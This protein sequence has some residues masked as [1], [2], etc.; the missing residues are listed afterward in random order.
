M[1][2]TPIVCD[3][4]SFQ[5]LRRVLQ[6]DLDIVAH[7]LVSFIPGLLIAVRKDYPLT[8]FRLAQVALISVRRPY[9]LLLHHDFCLLDPRVA[10]VAQEHN[11]RVLLSHFIDYLI[12]PLEQSL[13]LHL[14]RHIIQH[15][16]PF[17]R[18]KVA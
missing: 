4:D 17:F 9:L 5:V 15:N 16:K 14:T 10:V 1:E 3:L 12:V 11:N 7:A 13:A 18:S 6:K 8:L 2:D